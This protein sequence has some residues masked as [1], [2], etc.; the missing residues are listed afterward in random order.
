MNIVEGQ[1]F[2]I[3]IEKIIPQDI[4]ENAVVQLKKTVDFFVANHLRRS[5]SG[6]KHPIE[7]FLFTYYPF[8]VSLL[9]R[10]T[11]GFGF[12]LQG[13]SAEYFL[14]YTYYSRHNLGVWISPHSFPEHR[15]ESLK[16]VVVLLQETIKKNP[17][18]SCFGLHE[19]AMVYRVEKNRHDI[20][21]RLTSKQIDDFVDSQAISCS[22]YDAFRFFSPKARSLNGL[23]P[24]KKKQIQMEQGG[25]LH[26]NM[27]LY[28]WAFKFYPYI[29][30]TLLLEA[31]ILAK[32]IR[33]LDMQASPYDLTIFGYSPICIET[34]AGKA[35]YVQKQKE[36]SIRAAVLRQKILDQ[37][38]E[39]LQLI[40]HSV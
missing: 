39:L 28:K 32:E 20:P 35:I 19:W 12:V 7:D 1:I 15:I 29:S 27:D 24:D 22:H 4:W 37:L 11:P 31:F 9:K 30:S 18:F 36:F 34:T 40:T 10:F 5:A 2:D 33:T 17:H 14:K 13:D 6:Q 16:W 26:A 3:I 8:K 25:C 21:L 38:K 23:Q